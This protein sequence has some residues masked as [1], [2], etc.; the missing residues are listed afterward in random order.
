MYDAMKRLE[1]QHLRAAGLGVERTAGHA[2]VSPRTVERVSAEEPIEDVVAAEGAGRAG[3]GRPSKV[4]PYRERIEEWLKVEPE[5]SGIAVLQRLRDEGY[6]GGKSALYSALVDLRAHIP[7]EGIVRFEAVA[8][9]FGQHD[10]GECTVRYEGGSRERIQFFASRLKFSRV[11]RVRLVDDQT[12][13]TVCRSLVDAFDYFGGMPLI[14]VFDNPRTIVTS[15][16]GKV[17]RW[18]ETFAQFCGECGFAP[19]ATWPRRPREKGTVENLVGFAQTS[20][21][22]AYLFKDRRDLEEKL[23]EWHRWANDERISRATGETP[24]SRHMLEAPRLKP[25]QLDRAGWTLSYT[26]IVRTDGYLE[27]H[28]RRYFAG[29]E[30]VGKAL[31]VRVSEREVLVW[32]GTVHVATHPRFPLNGRY[33]ILPEQRAQVLEKSGARPFVKRQ[34]LADLCPAATWY[35]TELRHKRPELWREDVDRIFKLLEEHGEARVRD[36]LVEAARVATVGAEYL[37]ALL[38]GQ[39]RL[40]VRS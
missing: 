21:F 18:Q 22:K 24:R 33:S 1:I 17:V 13:E 27:L 8:G 36:A 40:E 32:A 30:H 34:L 38:L 9:E 6:T 11:V 16:E 35:M 10:F 37:E 15:R 28:E 3:L 5:L 39:G 23:V 12:T 29:F 4:E 7:P 20:F 14:C 26:R 2:G 25:V 19:H 31:T